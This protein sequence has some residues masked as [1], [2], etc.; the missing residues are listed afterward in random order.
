MLNELTKEPQKILLI[1][2]A[3]VDIEV[4]KQAILRS[5]INCGEIR[6]LFFGPEDKEDFPELQLNIERNGPENIE[7]PEE[8]YELI[9]D[10]DVLMVHF[11]PVS[12]KLID[13]AEHLKLIMT[14][15][16]GVEHINVEAA[17]SKNIPVVNCIRNA[18]AVGEFVIGLMIDMTRDITISHNFLHEGKWKREYY[19]SAYQKTLSNSIVG[20]IGMGN[21]GCV[22]AKKLL[23]LG[24]HTIVYDSFVTADSLAKKG[25][26]EL[27]YTD[28]LDYLLKTAD[29]VSLHLRLV[30]ETEKWF[31][32]EHFRKMRK[33]AYFI[34]SARGGILDYDALREALK[35]GLIAGAALDVFDKE[36]LDEDDPLLQMENVLVTSHLAGTTLDSIALSPYI[37]TRDVDEI[38]EKDIT[39]RIVNYKMLHKGE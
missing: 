21:I 16:G 27:E 2:D 12:S 28:D 26:G 9:R 18:D 10:T 39:D 11:C 35:Q 8:A 37:V 13:K 19:N 36:P 1:T 33:D 22:L 17:T 25:L 34:N 6:T 29:I 15:R 20:L 30:P 31:R 3:N 23:G 38:I 4:M 14:N 24:V 32:M 7:I 5:K